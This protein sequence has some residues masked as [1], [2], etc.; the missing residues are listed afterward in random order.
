MIAKNDVLV[1][2]SLNDI[3]DTYGEPQV[4]LNR[5]KEM[6]ITHILVRGGG[7]LRFSLVVKKSGLFNLLNKDFRE[8]AKELVPGFRGVYG[9]L[10]VNDSILDVMKEHVELE[11][12]E[13]NKDEVFQFKKQEKAFV[14]IVDYNGPYYTVNSGRYG[15]MVIITENFQSLN[16][17]TVKS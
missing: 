10:G 5:L 3:V 15:G 6:G 2:N 8:F 13:E 14:V 9:Y 17:K 4:P 12:T 11:G 16:V 7:Y 1:Y